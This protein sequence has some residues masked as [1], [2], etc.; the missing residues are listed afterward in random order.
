[1]GICKIFSKTTKQSF[2]NEKLQRKER[3]E[4]LYKIK[5][6]SEF[7]FFYNGLYEMTDR[8]W[9]NDRIKDATKFV[10]REVYVFDHAENVMKVVVR[11]TP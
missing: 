7:K 8:F 9:S 10:R 11:R 5:S 3:E 6:R 2:K 1:M 4:R